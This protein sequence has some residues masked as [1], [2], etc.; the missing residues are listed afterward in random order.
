MWKTFTFKRLA[1][2]HFKINARSGSRSNV[3]VLLSIGGSQSDHVAASETK[4]MLE[5]ENR[6]HRNEDIIRL[7]RIKLRERPSIDHM[8]AQ[9]EHLRDEGIAKIKAKIQ[10][11]MKEMQSK[12]AH[13]C[14]D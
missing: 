13:R 9:N 6:L 5:T 8:T 11:T 10:D 1:E 7:I 14:A 12:T 4:R 3:Y 2:R